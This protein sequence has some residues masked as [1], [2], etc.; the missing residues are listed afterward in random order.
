MSGAPVDS[1][2][3][4]QGGA[5]AGTGLAASG[6]RRELLRFIVNGLFATGVHYAVLT[7]N[8]QVLGF[9]SAGLANLCAAFAGITASF[10][11]SRFFV[12]ASAQPQ[13]LL[14]QALKFSGLYG[15]IAVLHGLALW[16]WTDKWGLDYR[17]GF[18]LA[19]GMQVSLSYLGNKFLVFKS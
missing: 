10:L 8:L 19:T 2:P 7:F 9:P 13:P 11:G 14:T 12:F 18:L 1:S 17:L 16:L 4:S 6:H 5:A 15:A 3:R